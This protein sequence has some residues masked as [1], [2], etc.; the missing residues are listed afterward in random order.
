MTEN[1]DPTPQELVSRL[2]DLL[3]VHDHGGDRFEGTR[4][5]GGVGRV[6]GGQ[7]IGQALASAERTVADDR[8][9]RSTP[10]FCAAATRITKSISR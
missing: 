6:F 10:I 9:T 3:N 1:E 4:K 2:L 8:S 7:V 5:I